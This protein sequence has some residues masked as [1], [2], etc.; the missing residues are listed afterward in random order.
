MGPNPIC[1]DP[2]KKRKLEQKHTQRKDPMKTQGEFNHIINQAE[3]PQIK[4]PE[5]TLIS[6][7]QAPEL[8]ENTFLFLKPPSGRYFV[9]QP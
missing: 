4:Q 2:S 6:A 3:K 1:W 7:F 8:G 9:T 5:N